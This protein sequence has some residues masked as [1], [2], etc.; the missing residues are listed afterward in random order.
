MDIKKSHRVDY[1]IVGENK[2]N[3]NI[4]GINGAILL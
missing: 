2:K 4:C 1:I 3:V